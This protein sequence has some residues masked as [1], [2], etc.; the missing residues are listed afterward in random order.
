MILN[1]RLYGA[2]PNST[3]YY[4]SLFLAFSARPD[5]ASYKV[6]SFPWSLSDMDVSVVDSGWNEVKSI[7]RGALRNPRPDRLFIFCHW[8]WGMDPKYAVPHYCPNTKSG[9]VIRDQTWHGWEALTENLSVLPV[10]LP[11]GQLFTP[12][13]NSTAR[14]VSGS[15]LDACM[16]S[17][18]EDG[19]G[20][21][22]MH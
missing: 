12:K 3:F 11:A 10:Q 7:G 17:A 18:A 9:V 22:S 8:L 20:L 14:A 15:K 13:G 4:L 2:A 5:I 1:F 16:W 21:T 19:R 6:P